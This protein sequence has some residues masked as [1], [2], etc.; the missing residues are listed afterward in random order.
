MPYRIRFLCFLPVLAL[1]A[2]ADWP[3][4]MGPGRNGVSPEKAL[5]LS[6]SDKGPPVLW[7][8]AV[9]EGYSAPVVA[10]DRLILFHRVGDEEVVECL[11]PATGQPRWKYTY[12]TSY[13]DWLNKGNG[14]RS[15]PLIADGKVFTLGPSGHLLCLDLATGK[16]SWD[17]EL[18]KDY[19]VRRSF[20]GVGTS[21]ILEGDIVAVNVGGRPDA[22]IVGFHKDTGKE[23]WRATDHDA[24]YASP[25]AATF[26][27]V[28]HLIFFTREGLVSLDPASGAVRFSRR[29]RPRINE[30]VNAAS[31]VVNGD[32]VFVSTSYN[33]GALVVRG[34]K[35]A[36]EEDIWKGDESLSCHFSTPVLHDGFLYGFDGRQESG[37]QFRCVEWQTGKVRWSKDGFGCGS[38]I[39]VQGLL[40]VLSE[41]GDLVVVEPNPEAYREKSRA[42]V[43]SGPVRAHMALADGRLFARDNRKLICFRLKK[44]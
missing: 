25:V 24:S 9:G 22:G 31:P 18:L 12:P 5:V 1:L 43:L 26:A 42:T 6:W 14:P 7:S 17:R 36:V 3:Q 40:L 21:P 29:W 37:T 4:F 15:T 38:L 27:G 30:S 16:K 10:G 11:D 41:S 32:Q 44:E 19:Q 13:Q 20:F 34:S 33:T 2:G 8:R 28:R 39:A 23:V 35:Q